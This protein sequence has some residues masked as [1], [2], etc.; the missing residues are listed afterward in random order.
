MKILMVSPE[1]APL[2]KIGGLGDVVGALPKAL[3]ARGHDVRVLCPLY[4]SIRRQPE[5][6]VVLSPL[7]VHLPGGSW[8]AQVWEVPFPGAPEVRLYLLEYNLFYQR[9][10]VY[11]GPWGDHPDND[12]RFTFL[13]RAAIDLGPALG[14]IP[15]VINGHDWTTGFTAVYLNHLGAPGPLE[16]TASVLTIHN[17]QHQGFC[18]PSVIGF[19]GLPASIL[20]PDN[21]EMN[22]SV[23]MLKA[24]IYNATKITT[25]SPTY[26]REIQTS[27]LGCDLDHI[28]KFR[29]GDLV[30]ILNGIDLHEWD[31]RRD[32]HLPQA[33]GAD[34]LAGKAADKAALQR[35][36]GLAVEPD[37]PLF[38]VVSRLYDQKGLDL[39]AMIA[40]RLMQNMRI[41]VVVLGAG[42]AAI[43]NGFRA[44]AEAW[45]GR[46]AARIGFDNGL[47]HRIYG[48]SDFF[49]MPSRFEPCGLSQMYAMRY[50]TPPVARATGG[51]VDTV[52]PYVEGDVGEGR[53]LLFEDATPG[54]LYD[55]IGWAT[56]VWYDRRDEYREL[57]Q[58]G[59]RAD[60]GWDEAAR[61]YEQ[62]YTWAAAARA[63]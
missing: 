58:N 27:E 5:W 49:L 24:G 56:H 44:A 48:G 52:M 39:L 13:S 26:A 18:H 11:A 2:V 62:V 23:S 36:C 50:G 19:A 12:R 16:R 15:D 1:V 43:E 54:A 41:Q 57:Q 20:R 4:G 32:P 9:P 10:E 38:G 53:G 42:D 17:L 28:L 63:Q 8:Y 40:D 14:W 61:Q 7:V 30:G 37:T 60:F 25:V 59:M 35:E 51:L 33:F 6:K 21:A 29:G 3:A 22:G 46:F 45:P 34:D 31:P 55:T 47:A